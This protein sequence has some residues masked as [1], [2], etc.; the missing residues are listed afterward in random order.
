MKR[1]FASLLLVAGS[2]A[3]LSAQGFG[4]LLKKPAPSSSSP[5]VDVGAAMLAGASMIGF[6]TIATDQGMKAMDLM[7]EV[8]PPEK[9]AKVKLLNLQ[10]KE[11]AAK[12]K[13]GNIDAEQLKVASS[14][15][16]EMA[17]IQGDWK[18][19][20][21]EKS[22]VVTKANSRLGLMLGA[23]AVAASAAPATLASLQE[24]GKSLASNPMQAGKAAQISAQV[25]VLS[26]V[27]AQIP[28]QTKS[29]STVRGIVSN[30]AKAEKITL[31]PDVSTDKVKD[32]AS[33]STSAKEL[34]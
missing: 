19:Y 20:K 4:N 7:M 27:V 22:A 5:K 32:Q 26:A 34:D 6:V 14:A 9:V 31:A 29:F 12:R 25:A 15:G 8:F 3:P 28:Q 33:L 18:S 23:D 17:A 24:A 13:D 21:K 30:I 2:V 11:L 1:T 16:Q 10:Y